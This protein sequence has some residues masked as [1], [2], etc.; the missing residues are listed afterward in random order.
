MSDPSLTSMLVDGIIS[1]INTELPDFVTTDGYLPLE[2]LDI[3]SLGRVPQAMV[4]DPNAATERL[5][6][7]Q[8]RET[9]TFRVFL[10][11]K[12]DGE[13]QNGLQIRADTQAFSIGVA[14][15]AALNNLT[16]S[17]SV[18][19]IELNEEGATYVAADILVTSVTDWN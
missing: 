1:V 18:S 7:H 10:L 14:N 8:V 13:G 15:D 19:V 5:S 9:N 16:D 6:F 12:Q 17:I 2:S 3:G 4:F 11:R